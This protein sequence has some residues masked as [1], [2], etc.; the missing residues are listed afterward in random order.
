M[1]KLIDT[2][3]L[4]PKPKKAGIAPLGKDTPCPFATLQVHAFNARLIIKTSAPMLW[5]TMPYEGY[6]IQYT[7]TP[8]LYPCIG[9]NRRDKDFV[10]KITDGKVTCEFTIPALP[11]DDQ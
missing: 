6:S 11:S 3:P 4:G 5:I 10:I 9:W 8:D 1:A 2:L 7:V